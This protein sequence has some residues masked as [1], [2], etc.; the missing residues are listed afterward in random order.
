MTSS[1]MTVTSL[2]LLLHLVLCMWFDQRLVVEAN[3]TPLSIDGWTTAAPRDEIRPEFFIAS[4]KPLRLGIRTDHRQGQMGYWSKSFPVE[5]TKYYQFRAVYAGHGIKSPRRC[6]VV[7]I[8]WRD[9]TGQKVSQDA[10]VLTSE[11]Q[12]YS[13]IAEAEHPPERG[14]GIDGNHEVSDIYRVPENA[15]QAIVELYLQWVSDAEIIWS[16][17]SMIP[18][19]P[20]SPR[21]VKFAAVHYHPKGPTSAENC[22]QYDTY[23]RQAHAQ[24]ADLIVLGETINLVASNKSAV[25]VAEPI[26]GPSSDHFTKL[27]KELNTHIVVGLFEKD[28]ALVYNTS[29]LCGPEGNIIGKYHKVT[30]PRDEIAWGVTP[31]EDYPVFETRFG[32]VGMMICYDGFYPEV[33]RELAKNGAEVIAW[34]VWGCN[35]LLASARACENHVYLVSSTF[36]EVQANWTRTAIYDHAGHLISAGNNWGDIAIAEVD[37]SRPT[38][39]PSLGDFRSSISRHKPVTV[40]E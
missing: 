23:V 13:A 10:D 12:N 15:T 24:G 29:I 3:D 25:E 34:P 22:A 40:P 17:V 37:L 16:D 20:P 5:G 38:R 36:T 2:S 27:S 9:A 32:K 21:K 39:W 18:T 33:A 8:H 28:G 11:L 7:K 31:G 30:L 6:A 19:T 14:P 26:P 4:E 1:R 35:P